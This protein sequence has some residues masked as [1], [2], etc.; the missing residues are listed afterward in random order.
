MKPPGPVGHSTP[1]ELVRDVETAKQ[2]QVAVE[3]VLRS[4]GA[5]V[6]WDDDRPQQQGPGPAPAGEQQQEEGQALAQA[7][8][9]RNPIMV[10]A[11]YVPEAGAPLAM[12]NRKP[13]EPT[14]GEQR[15]VLPCKGRL[16]SWDLEEPGRTRHSVLSHEVVSDPPQLNAPCSRILWSWPHPTPFY[17]NPIAPAALQPEV[18]AMKDELRRVQAVLGIAPLAAVP[19]LVAAPA[20]PAAPGPAPAPPAGMEQWGQPARE[21]RQPGDPPRNM[22][23]YGG[24][25]VRTLR[26]LWASRQRHID[27]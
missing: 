21:P 5:M 10:S 7:Q 18:G 20:G 22:G 15:L 16:A 9:Q 4:M 25:V 3:R 1:G 8:R 2:R 14:E 26:L 12:P 11:G 27:V 6:P 23:G 17:P 13:M 24:L 19:G